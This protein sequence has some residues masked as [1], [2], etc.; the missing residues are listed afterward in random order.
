MASIFDFPDVY[1]AVLRAPLPQID[2]EARSVRQLL[3][4]RGIAT[5]RLLE[6]ACGTCTHGILLAQQGFQVTGIDLSPN[7]VE[8]AMSRAAAAGVSLH[9]TQADIA[10]FTLED[11]PFDAAIFMAETF[12]ILTEYEGIASHFACVRQSMR[13][14]GVYIIDID[15]HRAGVR[16]EY[17]VWGERTEQVGDARVDIWHEN[18]PGDFVDG[19]SRLVMHCRIHADGAVH[20]TRDDWRIR[21]Y[22][23]WHL[24]ALVRTLAGWKLS[25]F[26]SRGSASHDIADDP[27]YL[28]TLEAV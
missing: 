5:G 13:R 27:G 12:P 15:A 24:S 10:D 28:M 9:V 23:P 25:G 18:F 6:L 7:M 16:D 4:R 21:Q 3:A 11:P 1:D 14:G 17:K 2:R 19:I 22:N 26:Y 20:E 8:A